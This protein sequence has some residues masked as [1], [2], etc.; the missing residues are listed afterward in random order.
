V[1]LVLLLKNQ[2]LFSFFNAPWL[3]KITWRMKI[4]I[5][6]QRLLLRTFTIDDAGLIY[7]LNNHP[8]VI[9]YTGDAITSIEL[10]KEMLEKTIL[11]QNAL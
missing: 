1:V 10:A 6:T 2:H 5:E 7:D 8:E 4:I 9:K 3:S 11:P